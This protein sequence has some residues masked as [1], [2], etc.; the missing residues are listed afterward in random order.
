MKL[1]AEFKFKS[2]ILVLIVIFN[3][4][5]TAYSNNLIFDDFIRYGHVLKF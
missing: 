1:F 3:L 2:V 5:L 4:T